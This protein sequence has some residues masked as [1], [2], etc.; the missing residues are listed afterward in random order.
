MIHSLFIGPRTLLNDC[1][2]SATAIFL[3]VSNNS[4]HDL[5]QDNSYIELPDPPTTVAATAPCAGGRP[6]TTTGTSGG[7]QTGTG[8]SN[9]TAVHPCLAAAAMSTAQGVQIQSTAARGCAVERRHLCRRL[10]V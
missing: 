4:Q 1:N 8:G 7:R 5:Y 10:W 6:A 9:S 2:H 3:G